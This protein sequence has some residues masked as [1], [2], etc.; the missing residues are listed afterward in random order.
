[1]IVVEVLNRLFIGLVLLGPPF[2]V[3]TREGFFPVVLGLRRGV[4]SVGAG[5]AGWLLL[6]EL[7]SLEVVVALD[8]VPAR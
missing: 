5:G 4:R 3:R 2:L 7:E 1:M 6:R 8:E